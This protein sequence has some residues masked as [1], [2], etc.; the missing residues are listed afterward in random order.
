MGVHGASVVAF[1]GG[2][3]AEDDDEELNA[4]PVGVGVVWSGERQRVVAVGAL[5][6]RWVWAAEF[7]PMASSTF[8]LYPFHAAVGLPGAENPL[9]DAWMDEE[10]EKGGIGR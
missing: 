8:H 4:P 9:P 2:A 3:R 5:S 1:R 10:G 7:G 6:S